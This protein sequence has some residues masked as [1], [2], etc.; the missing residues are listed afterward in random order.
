MSIGLVKKTINF[1]LWPNAPNFVLWRTISTWILKHIFS[2]TFHNSAYQ[3]IHVNDSTETPSPGAGSQFFFTYY[4]PGICLL[5]IL[6]IIISFCCVIFCFQCYNEVS[7]IYHMAFN[8][9]WFSNN[10]N[11]FQH[12]LTTNKCNL[13]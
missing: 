1:I 4:I 5:N 8:K 13:S 10:Q 3:G 2:F 9:N 6:Y 12:F 11:I 7:F